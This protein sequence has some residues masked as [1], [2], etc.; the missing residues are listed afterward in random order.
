M[1]GFVKVAVGDVYQS[2]NIAGSSVTGNNVPVATGV[3]A[4][5]S[6]NVGNYGRNQIG[7]LPEGCIKIGWDIT[8]HVRVYAGYDVLFLSSVMRPGNA[9]DP[10]INTSNVFSPTATSPARPAFVFTNSTFWAQGLNVG[11]EYHY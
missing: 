10:T 1:G 3:F 11:L 7:V 4:N 6:T 8:D 5:Y 9:I 2:V